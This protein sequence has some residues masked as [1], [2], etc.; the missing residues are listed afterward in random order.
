MFKNI[1]AAI[2]IAFFSSFA[3]AGSDP[4]FDEHMVDICVND[5]ALLRMYQQE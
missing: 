2:I 5:T 4:Y 3:T 1:L